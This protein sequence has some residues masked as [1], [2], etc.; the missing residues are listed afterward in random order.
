MTQN[1]KA[2]SVLCISMFYNTFAN[3]Y[4][5]YLKYYYGSSLK[6]I[7]NLHK[8]QFMTKRLLRYPL[9]KKAILEKNSKL[10]LD[11]ISTNLGSILNANQ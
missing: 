10:I 5:L 11:K 7:L 2:C 9:Q 6:Y 3:E 8:I 4:A 1:M